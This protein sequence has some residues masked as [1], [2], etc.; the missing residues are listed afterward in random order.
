MARFCPRFG[1]LTMHA[2]ET[3]AFSSDPTTGGLEGR[4]TRK[5]MENF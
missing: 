1:I 3:V 4:G 5:S 2:D